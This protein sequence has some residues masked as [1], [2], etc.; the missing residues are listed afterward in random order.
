MPAL[1]FNTDNFQQEVLSSNV[2]VLVDFW[3]EWCGPCRMMSPIVDQ[4]ADGNT[5]KFKVGKL[6]VDDDP[7]L[8]AR[9]EV[10]SIPTMIVFK[11]GEP[12]LRIV[13]AMTKEA[14]EQ[15]IKTVV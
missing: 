2:P 3:A 6:N 9:Y 5:G 8:A 13:G 12:A 14:L 10:M 11:N 15:K 1:H 7:E 4:V